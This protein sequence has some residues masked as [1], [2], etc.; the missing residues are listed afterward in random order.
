MICENFFFKIFVVNPQN[1]ADISL[2]VLSCNRRT[3]RH[4]FFLLFSYIYGSHELTPM[5]SSGNQPNLPT[6]F[7][8]YFWD[9][10]FED[11][12]WEKNPL[13]ISERILNYGNEQDIRWLLDNINKALLKSVIKNSRNLN[14]KTRNY[15]Q[16]M[17]A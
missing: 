17:L 8:K 7:R 11:L 12:S 13:F 14:A 3:Y 4:L 15:W 6:R 5:E 2:R 16:I 10:V 1:V 9:V